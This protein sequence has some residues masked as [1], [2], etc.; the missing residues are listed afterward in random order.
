MDR[1]LCTCPDRVRGD[2]GLEKFLNV[3]QLSC[4]KV[5]PKQARR[6]AQAVGESAWADQVDAEMLA[7][8]GGAPDLEAQKPPLESLHD[9]KELL[10]P[11]GKLNLDLAVGLDGPERFETGTPHNLNTHGIR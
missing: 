5:N 3:H 7:R 8:M 2:R 9:L 1:P 4:V 11:T 10:I 6:F